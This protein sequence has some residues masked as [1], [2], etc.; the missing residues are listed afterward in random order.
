MISATL[1][2]NGAGLDVS[3]LVTFVTSYAQ[4]Q[5]SLIK[6]RAPRPQHWYNVA[7]GNSEAHI[8]L[9]INTKEQLLACEI[10]INDD[11]EMFNFF[12]EKKDQIEKEIGASL[13]WKEADKACRIIQK[14]PGFSMENKGQMS[15][16]FKWSIDRIGVFGKVFG[17]Y[18]REYK[19]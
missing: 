17:Q 11:K 14:L 19:Q 12:L 16:Y 9:T 1:A 15:E 4:E 5:K 10:Y 2:K 6:F 8:A 7:I 18:I 3:S 13:E